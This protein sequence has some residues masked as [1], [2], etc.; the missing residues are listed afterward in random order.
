VNALHS[1]PWLV[2]VEALSLL[3]VGVFLWTELIESEPFRPRLARPFR[4]ALAAVS[5]WSIWVLAY[6]VALSHSAWYRSYPHHAGTGI[7]LSA[8]Q[9]LSAGVLWFASGT[10]FISLIFFNLFRWLKEEED[11]DDALGA[12]VRLERIRMGSAPAVGSA[13][14]L[15]GKGL[16]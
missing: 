2:F 13:T 5:M 14:A 9:Q 6:F 4:I 1:H 15:E 3:V 10:A 16:S 12:L 7:S 11:S 8:D